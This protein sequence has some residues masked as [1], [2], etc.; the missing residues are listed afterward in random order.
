MS[1]EYQ[2]SNRRTSGSVR[3]ISFSTKLATAPFSPSDL[4]DSDPLA[5]TARRRWP[6]SP[7]RCAGTSHPISGLHTGPDPPIPWPPQSMA[8]MVQR[9]PA[10]GDQFLQSRTSA[11]RSSRNRP[12]PRAWRCCAGPV[13]STARDTSR[14]GSPPTP[15]RIPG[16]NLAPSP[17]LPA[18]PG[19]YTPGD[20]RSAL[21]CRQIPCPSL[22][23]QLLVAPA[24]QHVGQRLIEAIPARRSLP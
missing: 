16:V 21:T 1:R 6:A 7:G 23:H 10:T 13:A 24:R 11:G 4:L 19:S 3:G 20:S 17:A 18:Q 9:V 12:T 2:L 15:D 14:A 5:T 8:S 22:L